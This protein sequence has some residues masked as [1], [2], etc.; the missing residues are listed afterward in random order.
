MSEEKSARSGDNKSA[1]SGGKK[2]IARVVT[3]TAIITAAALVI[4]AAVGFATGGFIPG[5]RGRASLTIDERK[6]LPLDGI[7]LVSIA[8]VSEHVSIVPG[9]GSTVDAWLHGTVDAS[10]REGLPHLVAERTGTTADIR[11]ER[12]SMSVGFFWG[13]LVLEVSIPA[14]YM[15]GL[16]AKTV[17]GDIDAADH[18]YAG[19]AMSTTSGS[20]RA[21]H[22]SVSELSVHTTSGGVTA[23]SVSAK[24]SD[25]SAVSG[26]VKVKSLTGDATVGTTSGGIQLAFVAVPSRVDA[27]ST[28]GD[29]KVSF[30]AASQF[31]LDARSTSGDVRCAFP[32]TIGENASGGGHHVLSGTIGTGTGAV[33][34]HTV[35]G[36]IRVE[37]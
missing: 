18:T 34:L 25:I 14:A 19:L 6:S 22:M 20:I 7:D 8:A 29:V 36:D 26:D 23:Q 2:S 24:S 31:A 12:P 37:K 21:G 15:K 35:S 30:P 13:D 4:A 33:T 10:S 9:T 27:G 17:S 1:R 32:I 28:S 11:S 3:I 16:E 5:S